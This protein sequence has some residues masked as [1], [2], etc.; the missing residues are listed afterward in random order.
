MVK[1]GGWFDMITGLLAPTRY[2]LNQNQVNKTKINEL[3]VGE[4][5]RVTYWLWIPL[6]E[7]E[8]EPINTWAYTTPP[9]LAN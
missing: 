7:E 3:A 6:W 8:H 5:M 1:S 9:V 2:Q 4:Y